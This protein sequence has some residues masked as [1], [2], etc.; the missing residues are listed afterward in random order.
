MSVLALLLSAALAASTGD[1]GK[2]VGRVT[3]EVG[4]PILG[5]TVQLLGTL[6]GAMTDP[7]GE[8]FVINVAPGAYDVQARRIDYGAV[9]REDCEV[10]A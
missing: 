9:T 4:N 1:T 2:I 6:Y 8:F 5:A 10:I 7:N 3:D